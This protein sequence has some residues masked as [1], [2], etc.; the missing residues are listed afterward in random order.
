MAEREKSLIESMRE[1]ISSNNNKYSPA[2]QKQNRGI[3]SEDPFI[4][5]D[6]EDNIPNYIKDQSYLKGDSRATIVQ[7]GIEQFGKAV[8][9]D[10]VGVGKAI[11]TGIYESGVDFVKAPIKTTYDFGSGVVKSI[12]NVGTKSLSDYLPE[13][14]TEDRATAEQMTAARQA[15]LSDYLNAS[16]IIPAASVV[17]QSGR[18]INKAIPTSTKADISG[19]LKALTKGDIQFLRESKNSNLQGVG[20]DVVKTVAIGDN[21][22]PEL[23]PTI[24][25]DDPGINP[26]KPKS[27]VA[28]LVRPLDA[29]VTPITDR[30]DFY[31]PILA[32]LDNLPIGKDGMLGSNIIKFLT[33]KASNINKTELN[34]SQLLSPGE[35]LLRASSADK[36]FGI[37]PNRKYTKIEIKLL[38]KQNLPQIMI[39]VRNGESQLLPTR[40]GGDDRRDTQRVPVIL[41]EQNVNTA[42]STQERRRIAFEQVLAAYQ[43]VDVELP[44]PETMNQLITDRVN[45]LNSISPEFANGKDYVEI[46]LKNKNSLGNE[47]R[48]SKAHFPDHRD[49]DTIVAHARGS[50]YKLPIPFSTLTKKVFIVEELQTDAIQRSSGGGRVATEKT[51]DEIKTYLSNKKNIPEIGSPEYTENLAA[52]LEELIKKN[53]ENYFVNPAERFDR[54]AGIDTNFDLFEEQRLKLKQTVFKL[55]EDVSTAK[56]IFDAGSWI[57]EDVIDFFIA[58]YNKF[59]IKESSLLRGAKD[60]TGT[61]KIDKILSN[62]IGDIIYTKSQVRQYGLQPKILDAISNAAIKTPKLDLSPLKLSETVRSSL[63]AAMK[64]AKDNES[65]TLVIPPVKDIVKAH[66]GSKEAFDITYNTSVLKTLKSLNSETNGQITFKTSKLKGLDFKSGEN[67]I[68]VD[69]SKFDIPKDSQ[70]RLAE[71]GVVMEEQMQKILQEGGIADDGMNR[72]PV[73]G[74]EIP[75]GSLASEV[76][77]DIPAQLSGGEYVVP[78]DVTRFYGVKFFEDLRKDAKAG[79]AE[80]ESNGRIGGSQAPTPDP[81]TEQVS[82]A[83]IAQIEQMLSDQGMAAGGLAQGG[84]MDKLV[85]AAK[86]NRLVNERMRAFGMPLEMAMGGPVGQQSPNNNMYSDPNKIDSIISKI[87]SAAQKNP[88]L[89]QMLSER[90]INVPSNLA[91]Q[92]SQEIQQN[93]SPS[94]TTEPIMKVDKGGFIPVENYTEVQ[95]MIANKANKSLPAPVKAANGIDMGYSIAD[96]LS[97]PS[98]PT[99]YLTPGSMTM[100][101]TSTNFSPTQ[102]GPQEPVGGCAEGFIWN[103]VA[104]IPQEIVTQTNNNNDDDNNFNKNPPKPWYEGEDLSDMDAFVTGKL[105]EKAPATGLGGIVQNIPIVKAFSRLDKYNN[106]AETRAGISLALAANQITPE[107]ADVLTGKVDSYIE[108]NDLSSFW[109]ESL[110]TGSGMAKNA[111]S[112]F[113]GEDGEFDQDE[114]NKFVTETGGVIE[115]TKTTVPTQTKDETQAI[116]NK[117][118]RLSTQQDQQDDQRGQDKRDAKARA[119]KIIKEKEAIGPKASVQ[120]VVKARAKTDKGQAAAAKKKAD[121]DAASKAGVTGG[122]SGGMNKG[123]LMKKKN[124]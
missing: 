96:V 20:A 107:E 53:T 73:S 30:G 106:V 36:I 80:M 99:S 22:G 7:E 12:K 54:L 102:Q 4:I 61:Q 119:A 122:S 39:E 78:A 111:T 57:D 62:A 69:F 97:E 18:I 95:D 82:D 67:Y 47:F 35:R 9:D 6:G 65:N 115:P 75:S 76:R 16:A 48:A 27:E 50:F 105:S 98:L 41:T 24:D 1:Y 26:T 60:L 116:I 25:S 100:G 29:D 90:G 71:G 120:D 108:K 109:T 89:M 113:A 2:V 110:F 45:Q 83:D 118:S 66:D 101:N 124:K 51:T 117:S 32:N 21:Q 70:L 68:I 112:L 19:K 84:M 88:Q 34:W 37:D 64:N 86:T 42:L 123:G 85:N 14:I 121:D 77:D 94:Q 87:S 17:R 52:D 72:D 23:E 11:G 8:Y 44:D 58:E 91:T 74:N 40:Y 59:G 79:L 93:N 31:S 55:S 3:G 103:G 28:P 56:K 92:N 15:Q 114:W 33:K 104:C 81:D 38:A 46:F 13:G 5:G 49:A 63:L 43:D 10:P